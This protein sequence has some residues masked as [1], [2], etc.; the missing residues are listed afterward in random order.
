[1]SFLYDLSYS[2]PTSKIITM[3]Q[4]SKLLD[5][6]L[7]KAQHSLRILV[8]QAYLDRKLQA[9]I[10]AKKNGISK[11]SEMY[12]ISGVSLTS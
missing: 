8:K 11:V 4:V 12:D 2:T 7:I 10:A 6:P 9:V 5:T 1:M 3:T